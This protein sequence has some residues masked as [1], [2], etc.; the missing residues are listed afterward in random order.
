MPLPAFARLAGAAALSLA[1][2]G[3]MDVTVD[4]A[5]LSETAARS[6]VTQFIS[7]DFYPMMQMSMEGEDEV[8][9]EEGTLTENPEGSAVCVIVQEGPF[10]SLVTGPEGEES[11]IRF[12]SAG[13]GLVRVGFDTEGLSDEV[14]GDDELDDE[15]RQMMEAIL[16]G[17]TITLRISGGEV[18]ETNMERVDGGAQTVILLLDLLDGGLDMPDELY[19]VIRVN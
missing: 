14:G 10:A 19:A 17:N 16:A 8:L 9:C 3:C 6:T 4:V 5:V 12:S 2:A 13:A 11:G 15:T 18:V 7:A 1:L